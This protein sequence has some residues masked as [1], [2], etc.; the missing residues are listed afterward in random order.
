MRLT[1]LGRAKV[2]PKSVQT[3]SVLLLLYTSS[4]FIKDGWVFYC[5]LRG[6]EKE[7]KMHPFMNA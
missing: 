4:K 6:G 5:C 3:Q 1:S 7:K 2:P